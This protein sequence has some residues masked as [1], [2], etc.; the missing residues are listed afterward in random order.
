MRIA[1]CDGKVFA[2]GLLAMLA[3]GPN[4][5]FADDLTSASYRLRAIHVESLG[6]AWLFDGSVRRSGVSSGQPEAIGPGSASGGLAGA[7]PG[8]WPI[9]AGDLPS[10]DLDGDG[11]AN[12]FDADDDGDGL[13]DS[14]ESNTGILVSDQDTGT[15]PLDP[16][17]DGDGFEDGTE[18][19]AGTDPNDPNS[20]PPL[21]APVPFLS[22][23]GL[24][25]LAAGLAGIA[26][27]QLRRRRDDDDDSTA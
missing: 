1:T 5:A 3:A 20:H 2:A 17:S 10:V 8:F 15:D 23:P 9:V 25:A 7:W 18:L 11:I 12:A 6:P 4:P 27:R 16:D 24:A 13:P 21:P 22:G 19:V 14:A 26:Y